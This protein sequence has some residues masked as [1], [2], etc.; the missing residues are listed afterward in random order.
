[1][2]K[3]Q[4][5]GI[6]ISFF[7]TCCVPVCAQSIVFEKEIDYNKMYFR[8]LENTFRINI[9]W[10]I[11]TVSLSEQS[12]SEID[13]LIRYFNS[14]DTSVPIDIC[15]WDYDCIQSSAT[16]YRKRGYYL[17]DYLKERLNYSNMRVYYSSVD[18]ERWEKENSLP[19]RRTLFFK[20]KKN[21]EQE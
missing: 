17:F 5:F 10:E 7:I 3:Q 16:L 15:Y 12:K 8:E 18:C 9:Y 6:V 20:F 19:L 11:G 21:N 1:M 4:V 14:F 13:S 2:N